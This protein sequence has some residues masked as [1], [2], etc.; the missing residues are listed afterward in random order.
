VIAKRQAIR[1][2]AKRTKTSQASKI[3]QAH[4]VTVVGLRM[5]IYGVG[6]EPTILLC[7]VRAFCLG[8]NQSFWIGLHQRCVNRRSTAPVICPG[9]TCR[10]PGLRYT[11]AFK[12]RASEVNKT[13][14]HKPSKRGRFF[15]S[16]CLVVGKVGVKLGGIYFGMI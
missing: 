4:A 10:S 16:S 11:Q 7:F 13:Q 3:L 9:T 6:I 14:S 1:I 15:R 2:T 5:D 8:I 12:S